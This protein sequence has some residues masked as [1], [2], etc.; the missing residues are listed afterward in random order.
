MWQITSFG[1]AIDEGG[2][3]NSAGENRNAGGIDLGDQ[4][5]GA[6]KVNALFRI[7]GEMTA[8]GGFACAGTGYFRTTGGT[9]LAEGAGLA[10]VVLGGL[11][12]VF[13]ARPAKT[14]SGEGI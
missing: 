4:L 3:P 11:G 5:P 14:W 13:N 10:L 8:D 2:D 9:P 12:G 7:S 6:A 1:N